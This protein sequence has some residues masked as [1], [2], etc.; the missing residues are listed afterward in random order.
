MFLYISEY[1]DVSRS[2][3]FLLELATPCVID[4]SLMAGTTFD[5]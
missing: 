2:H 5:L 1:A 4:C 3:V